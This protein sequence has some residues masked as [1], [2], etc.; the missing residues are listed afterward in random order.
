MQQSPNSSVEEYKRAMLVV[1]QHNFEALKYAQYNMRD[2]ETLARTAVLHH[3]RAFKYVSDRLRLSK[4][5]IES[6]IANADYYVILPYIDHT[7]LSDRA[8][9]NRII[10]ASPDAVEYL[11]AH[12]LGDKELML[13]LVAKDGWN[14]QHVNW[15][16]RVD[17]DLV[18]IALMHDGSIL[19]ILDNSIC[20]DYELA[21][22]SIYSQPASFECL[23]S[24]LR[25]DSKLLVFAISHH[26]CI[27]YLDNTTIGVSLR[28]RGYSTLDI[29]VCARLSQ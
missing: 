20:D 5:F 22:I 27:E 12:L 2:D 11:N 21:L 7:L 28:V 6:I 14:I 10:V 29:V 25:N 1:V 3:S 4:P 18:E 26:P 13:E 8:F 23:S 19:S 15:A 17:R 9:M 24:R 16:M